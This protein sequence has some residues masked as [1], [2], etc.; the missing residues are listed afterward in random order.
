MAKGITERHAR[1]C[2][3]REGRC[4]C[5]PSYQAQ[6]YDRSTGKRLMRTFATI[7]AA[8]QW[9]GDAYAAIRAVPDRRP[10]ADPPGGRRRLARRCPGG[11]RPKPVGRHLQ[12]RRVAVL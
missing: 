11:D 6:V 12:A 5:T 3:H 1:S 9:H 8:K 10:W 4:T 2:D 7:T